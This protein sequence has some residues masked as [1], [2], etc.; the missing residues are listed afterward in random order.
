MYDTNNMEII[1]Y[2]ESAHSF[3]PFIEMTRN[4]DCYLIA[5]KRGHINLLHRLES[6]FGWDITITTPTH[7]ALEVAKDISKKFN[8]KDDV[9][10][11]FY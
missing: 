11:N 3:H 10:Y 2:L 5:L 6:D 1:N 9:L 4:V 8:K 7:S